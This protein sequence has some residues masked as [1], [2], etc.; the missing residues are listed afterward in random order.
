MR[1][2]LILALCLGA[3]GAARAQFQP[4]QP[5]PG[6]PGIPNVAGPKAPPNPAFR[7]SQGY[8]PPKASAD[9]FSPAGQAERERRAARAGQARTNGVFSPEG[10]A[11]RAREQAKRDR[12]LNPF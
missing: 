9:P 4:I 5:V 6:I 1:L 2:A 12:A 8:Q 11:K 3:A 7:P 10:E